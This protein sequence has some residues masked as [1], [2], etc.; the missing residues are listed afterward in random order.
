MAAV[1]QPV[2]RPGTP[3]GPRSFRAQESGAGRRPGVPAGPFSLWGEGGPSPQPQSLPSGAPAPVAPPPGRGPGLPP[4]SR[5]HL[6]LGVPARL[7][8]P[9]A[10]PLGV[11]ESLSSV[12]G[13]VGPQCR[14]GAWGLWGDGPPVLWWGLRSGGDCCFPEDCEIPSLQIIE[15]NLNGDL[16]LK[17]ESEIVCVTTHFKDL[18]NP[19]S[20]RFSSRLGFASEKLVVSH[21]PGASNQGEGAPRACRAPGERTGNRWACPPLQRVGG[22][23]AGGR[24]CARAEGARGLGTGALP[25]LEPPC[26]P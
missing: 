2:V 9:R 23:L 18:G 16:N 25:A 6:P 11:P 20:G 4:A 12:A 26:V 8:T 21:L 22:L 15:A 14:A 24:V 3:G 10:P 5:L 1:V 13:A 17:I 7:S 19:P